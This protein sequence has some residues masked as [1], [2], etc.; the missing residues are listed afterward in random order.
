[1]SPDYPDLKPKKSQKSEISQYIGEYG[2]V[3]LGMSDTRKQTSPRSAAVPY[4]VVERCREK[5]YSHLL[6]RKEEQSY[7][8]ANSG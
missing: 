2:D 6:A 5:Y 7:E 8:D 1:L 3:P 4:F